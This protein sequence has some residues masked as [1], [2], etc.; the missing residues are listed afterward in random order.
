[1]LRRSAKT[2]LTAAVVAGVLGTG[3]AVAA[4]PPTCPYGNTPQATQT[5]TQTQTTTQRHLRERDGTGPRHA[6]RVRDGLGTGGQTRHHGS[7]YQGAGN[8]S[9][10]YRS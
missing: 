4:D 2:V 5:Q 8:P 1:M 7:G 3:V 6:Q 10:P 9:C